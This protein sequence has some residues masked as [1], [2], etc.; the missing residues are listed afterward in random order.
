MKMTVMMTMMMM[1]PVCRR[2][3][4][5]ITHLDT[6]ACQH[7]CYH[8]VVMMMMMMMR[9]TMIVT[10]I[11]MMCF[12]QA[13]LGARQQCRRCSINSPQL[14]LLVSIIIII[15]IIIIIVM[16]LGGE[17]GVFQMVKETPQNFLLL[18][19]LWNFQICSFWFCVI[20]FYWC[21]RPYFPLFCV[22]FS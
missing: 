19:W 8:Q 10:I 13:S 21:W 20:S 9:M 5:A 18:F 2:S 16:L 7:I 22:P 1:T 15:I 4:K 17:G 11:L 14:P 6:A 12:L 3:R